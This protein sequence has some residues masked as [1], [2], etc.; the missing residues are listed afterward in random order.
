M[1]ITVTLTPALDKTAVIPGFALGKVN[2]IAS[3]RVDAGGK[4][5]NVS[6]TLAVLGEK[7]LA[8]GILGGANGETI[9]ESLEQSGIAN[10][11][12][13][14]AANTRTNL[15]VVDPLGQTHTDVNEPGEPV[16]GDTLEAVLRRVEDKAQP[17]DLVVLAG[18][19]PQGTPD[20]L[21]GDWTLRLKAK[22]VLVY[23]DADGGLLIEG[24]KACPALIKPNDEELARLCGHSFTTPAEMA[25]AAQDLVQGGIGTVVVSLGS[26][27]AL[28][29]QGEEV[30]RGYGLHVPVASTVGA[31]DSMM[32][33][34]CLGAV[35]D[36]GF[37][38]TCRLA[39]AVSA[40]TVM[41]PGT[42][43]AQWAEV[44]NLL[45]QVRLEKMKLSRA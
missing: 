26:A 8:T 2:R 28:F 41:R 37:F 27:G 36:M 30:L 11:F 9:R 7:S 17:G 5:I 12:V 18:K 35:R 25:R 6:K 42:Q 21:F 38:E 23:L 10:D 22:G 40:A 19:A 3:M 15:K 24:A 13:F 29:V 16:D 44:E 32:A 34:M 45:P 33:A 4:G 14:V 31:G 43:P 39:L 1:I 20:T